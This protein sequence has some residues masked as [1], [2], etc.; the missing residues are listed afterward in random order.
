M[1]THYLALAA[2]LAISPLTAAF[3]QGT[4][5]NTK[6]DSTAASAA[7]KNGAATNP[8]QPGST[9]STVVT[10]DKSTVTGDHKATGEQKTGNISGK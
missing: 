5:P 7:M 10:G 8:N 1:K 9:G 3:A 2:A 4:G 6:A